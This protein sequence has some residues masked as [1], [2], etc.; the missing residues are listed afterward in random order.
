[1]IRLFI[2]RRLVAG[3]DQAQLEGSRRILKNNL[4]NR[5]LS[6]RVGINH[7]HLTLLNEQD[8]FVIEEI[9]QKGFRARVSARAIVRLKQGDVYEGRIR[10]LNENFDL[11]ARI[12][13]KSEDS[14]GFEIA[15]M[16]EST[17]SWIN[18]LIKPV[19]IAAN[20]NEIKAGF[21]EGGTEGKSWYRSDTGVDLVVWKNFHEDVIAWKLTLPGFFIQWSTQNGLV[22]GE[23]SLPTDPT[24]LSEIDR[25]QLNIGNPDS[26]V[27]LLKKQFAEDLIVAIRFPIRKKLLETMSELEV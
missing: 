7:K 4:S 8:I 13:W 11:S 2:R 9:S 12:A 16:P 10:Y 26:E 17:A 6:E 1:M 5:R 18:R 14:I 21:I 22:T 25:N 15:E 24:D 20:L 3:T 19:Q 27:D 23:L